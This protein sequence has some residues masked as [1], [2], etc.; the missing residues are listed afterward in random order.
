MEAMDLIMIPHGSRLYWTTGW[1]KT[2]LKMKRSNG[3]VTVLPCCRENFVGSVGVLCFDT[4]FDFSS[5]T[6]DPD[7][8][9]DH[10][11][12]WARFYTGRVRSELIESEKRLGRG[13]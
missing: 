11:P 2:V 10:F 8:V 12:V 6:L 13:S 4:I 9:S 7:D 5:P 3:Y 1:R